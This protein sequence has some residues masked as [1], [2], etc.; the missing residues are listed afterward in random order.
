MISIIIV[1]PWLLFSFFNTFNPLYP[2]FTNVYPVH[3]DQSWSLSKIFTDVWKLFTATEDPISPLY[4]TFLPLVFFVY[5]KMKIQLKTICLYS[6]FSLFIWYITPRTG[7]GR[8]IL[9]YLP[10]FSLLIVFLM[11]K[12]IEIRK[13]SLVLVIVVAIITIGYRGLANSRY[14]PVLFGKE[15][16]AEFLT[17]HLNFGY[18]DFYDT[19][20]YF[21]QKIKHSG[22][23]LFYGFHNLYYVDFSFID[24]S[25]VK[26]GDKFSYIAVQ[27]ASLPSQ[28]SKWSKIYY[29]TKTGVNVY[30]LGEREWVY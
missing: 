6:F 13:F 5:K 16:K 19:D 2:L 29:N 4:I 10:S 9:P 14:L 23:V 30:T 3:F 25:W 27:N 20:G 15:T 17:N 24:S 28:F 21:A 12:I 26:R 11:Q 8:F 1:S 18:G 22:T 7:G